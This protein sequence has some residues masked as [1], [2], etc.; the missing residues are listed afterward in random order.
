MLVS[1]VDA[2]INV[3]VMTDSPALADGTLETE[4]TEL[5]VRYLKRDT[6]PA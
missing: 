2:H 1:T 4:L 5:V 3:A 6:F